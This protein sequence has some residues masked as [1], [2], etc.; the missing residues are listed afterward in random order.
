MECYGV[1][2]G[3]VAGLLGTIVMCA[4]EIVPWR[5]WG[6]QGVFEWHENQMLIVKFFKLE[7]NGVLHYRGIF[8]LHFLNGMLGGI[9]FYLALELVDYL[10]IVP[11][12]ILGI[13]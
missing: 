4:I 11:L 3:A 2:F 5:K 10:A 1:V 13:A 12:P 9:G 6:L 7:N 8:G